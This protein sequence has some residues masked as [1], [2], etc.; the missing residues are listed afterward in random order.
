[1]AGF[2][3][4]HRGWFCAPLDNRKNAYFYKHA[5]GDAMGDMFYSLI[6]T[7][8]LNGVNPFHYLTAL[9]KHAHVVA[10][11]PGDRMPWNYQDVLPTEHMSR[12]T[13]E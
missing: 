2:Q 12:V 11:S 7:C 13:L 1:V 9:Q 3:R 6:H 4:A 10:V 5:N 8:E